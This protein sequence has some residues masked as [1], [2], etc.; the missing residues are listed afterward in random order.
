MKLI[1]TLAI[2]YFVMSITNKYLCECSLAENFVSIQTKT[3]P[4]GEFFP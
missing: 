2:S 1:L 4:V 3:T